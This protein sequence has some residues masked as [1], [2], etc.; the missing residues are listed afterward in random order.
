MVN[1]AART[2]GSQWGHRTPR[3]GANRATS[4]KGQESERVE[5]FWGVAGRGQVAGRWGRGLL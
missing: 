2:P 5:Q 3:T 1:E 4:P